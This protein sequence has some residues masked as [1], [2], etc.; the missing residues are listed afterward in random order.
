MQLVI[1]VVTIAGGGES[2]ARV[3]FC[4]SSAN[5]CSKEYVDGFSNLTAARLGCC[6]VRF[7]PKKMTPKFS[8]MI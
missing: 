8:L 1:L 3:L 5:F 4:I 6:R 2:N 7:A